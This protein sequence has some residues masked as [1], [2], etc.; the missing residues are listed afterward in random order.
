MHRVGISP[1]EFT[2][3]TIMDAFCNKSQINTALD[4]FDEMQGEGIKP[5]TA[6]INCLM[7]GYNRLGMID[8]VLFLYKEMKRL[9]NVLP[10][11]VSISIA[12]E[13]CAYAKYY[14]KGKALYNKL[15][16]TDYP[17]TERNFRSYALLLGKA[18]D[19]ADLVK[20]VRTMK[21]RDVKPERITILSILSCVE[22]ASDTGYIMEIW[23]LLKGW[24]EPSVLPYENNVF[25][26]KKKF[27]RI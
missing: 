3:C 26:F 23:N 7:D 27:T 8:N 12:I 19:F 17:F 11:S 9:W 2:Y 4:F 18:G 15:F 25:R 21:E 13:A 5:D 16:S 20:L 14:G 6:V 22:E 1:N 24:V 10:D